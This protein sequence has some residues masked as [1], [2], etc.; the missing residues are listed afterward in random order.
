MKAVILDAATCRVNK[1]SF[2]KIEQA[3]DQ[4]VTYDLTAKEEIYTR[5][6]DAEAVFTNKC[7]LDKDILSQCPNLKYIG[8]MATGYN[9][10]D[11]EYA[12]QQGIRV[13]NVPAYSTA[14]VAQMTFALLFAVTN[15]VQPH[16]DSVHRGDW[17]N[18]PL[19]TYSLFEQTELEGKVMGIIGFGDIG[20]RVSQI[21]L[22]L[23]MRVLVYS[24]TK[25]PQYD[26][27]KLQFV[28]LNQLLRNSDVI[29]LHCPLSA[30]TEKMIDADAICQM[31][32][33]A[34]VLNT[35]R[36]GLIDE[37]ALASALNSGKIAAAAVDVLS[38]EPPKE[39]NP[40]LSAKNCVITPH[41]AWA[42][43]EAKMRLLNV[44]EQNFVDWLS[45][46]QT[47]VIA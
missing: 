6:K 10:I 3:V 21:A 22:A 20:I 38:E 9:N 16:S 7:V 12:R 46:R 26:N 27:E 19:F 35:A 36:G 28:P 39:S 11:I 4:L 29:S 37:S 2:N 8:E 47:N 45:N 41:I 25:K 23:G 42:S 1:P 30:D 44:V 43:N 18:S 24:R 14:S 31:K 32:P 17:C 5:I 33:N 15:T 13:T 34:I 40:L